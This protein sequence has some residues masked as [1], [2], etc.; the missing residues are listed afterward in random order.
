MALAFPP[1]T[2]RELAYH[3]LEQHRQGGQW[4]QDLLGQAIQAGLFPAS[5][6][7]LATELVYGVVRRRGTLLTV[8][9]AVLPRP[10]SQV[11]PPLLTLLQLGAYQLLFLDRIPAY[12]AVHETVEL[13]RSLGQLRWTKFVNGVL[14]GV[15]RLLTETWCDSPAPDA[16]PI[17][18]GRFRRLKRPLFPDPQREPVAYV[19]Q[20]YSLPAWLVVRWQSRWSWDQ[21]L[22][23]A[24]AANTPPRLYV[25]VNQTRISPQE[26]L[27]RWTEAGLR[28]SLHPELPVLAVEH[29]GDI[30]LWPGYAEGWW[31]PQD[32]TSV[33][34]ALLLAPPAG[35]TVWDVCAAPGGKSTHLAELV[36]P[37]GTV[38]AT[39]V[40]TDRL[41]RVRENAQRLGF[42]NIRTVVVQEDGADWPTGPFDAVLLDAPCSNTGVLHRR[43]EVRWRLQPRDLVE[44]SALQQ[45][46]LQ[47]ALDRLRRGG[48]LVYSTCSIEPEENEQVIETILRQRDE[49]VLCT[50]RLFLPGPTGD[51][52]YQALLHKTG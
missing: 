25:R 29:S 17:T 3:V 21:L 12:A 8:L 5:E 7:G 51:G 42:S 40:H 48:R 27:T 43:P 33:R 20:A 11:E 6:R 38:W 10:L 2:A 32:V 46:L 37:H 50:S 41:G 1:R 45:R 26:L 30:E 23:L 4:V 47:A 22:S 15:T 9:A 16:V 14:R 28:A 39:D 35:G 13:T 36:G 31:L 19:S 44:L 34:A 24:E 49:M 18:P 52:G